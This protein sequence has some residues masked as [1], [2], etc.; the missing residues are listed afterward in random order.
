MPYVGYIQGP[1]FLL[2]ITCA[3]TTCLLALEFCFLLCSTLVIYHQIS[4]CSYD[5][6]FYSCPIACFLDLNLHL[7]SSHAGDTGY[8]SSFQLYEYVC[9]YILP[10]YTCKALLSNILFIL[11]P[12]LFIAYYQCSFTFNLY[13][14]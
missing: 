4:L 1:S 7:P 13:Q 14:K 2:Q 10:L 9:I 11:L 6:K 12:S 3:N 5:Y 8:S